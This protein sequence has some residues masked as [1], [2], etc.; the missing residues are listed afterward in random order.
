MLSSSKYS[1]FL[2]NSLQKSP[3]PLK[4]SYF[5]LFPQKF[6]N[7]GIGYPPKPEEKGLKMYF[8]YTKEVN[9]IEV[10]AREGETLLEVAHNNKVELEGACE[11]SLACS[12]CHVILEP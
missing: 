2:F 4:P 11:Q 6:F 10:M 3:L 1:K 12:T 5:F 9:K 8:Q 7:V